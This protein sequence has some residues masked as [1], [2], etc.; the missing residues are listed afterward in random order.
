VE[1][2]N[3]VSEYILDCIQETKPRVVGNDK[4]GSW[5]P[6]FPSSTK[7]IVFGQSIL[8]SYISVIY[9]LQTMHKNA[10]ISVQNVKT[11]LWNG[12]KPLVEI[13]GTKI[14]SIL[15]KQGKRELLELVKK[16][17]STLEHVIFSDEYYLTD[18]DWWVLARSANIPI[19]LFSSTTLKMLFGPVSWLRL[20]SVNSVGEK[21]F[22]VRSPAEV[23]KNA[24]GSYHI[25]TDRFAFSQLKGSGGT[26]FLEAERGSPQYAEHMQTLEEFLSKYHV[27]SKV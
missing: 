13:Y 7:E 8:C 25:L 26:A 17:R 11:A 4:A 12:Y 24:P 9:L 5:R 2:K 18:L 20:S 27:V 6:L 1:K 10:N 14:V 19:I 3:S 21:Y 22:F 16:G 15:Q 23:K